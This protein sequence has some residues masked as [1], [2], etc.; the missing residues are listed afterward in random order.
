MS[1]IG[2]EISD[3]LEK[4]FANEFLKIYLS[5][6]FGNMSKREMDVLIFHLL[7]KNNALNNKSNHLLALQL[8]TTPVK[9]KALAYEAKLRFPDEESTF[10]EDYFKE[11][12]REYFKEP[13]IKVRK[14]DSWVYIQID[15]PILM[16]SFKAIAK[17]N[18]EVIDKS[19]NEEIVKISIEGFMLVIQEL[20][21]KKKLEELN[22]LIKKELKG[23]SIF[24]LT[25]LGDKVI[26]GIISAGIKDAPSKIGK[27][28]SWI[29]SMNPTEL[30]EKVAQYL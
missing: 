4:S 5:R 21:D 13:T 27:F 3:T 11:K 26:G 20:V 18:K 1:N 9:I 22:K 25:N 23:K 8:R 28:A 30:L 7:Q 24:S 2:V 15:D 29:I 12:L 10:T 17:N 6:G 19:F 16:D 14:N